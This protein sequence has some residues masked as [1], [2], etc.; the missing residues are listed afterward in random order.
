MVP[1]FN[2]I[3]PKYITLFITDYGEHTP[4]YMYRLFSEY[5]DKEL[6]PLLLILFD[7]N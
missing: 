7:Y 3:Q 2:Y 6:W 5:Y 4:A 1:K